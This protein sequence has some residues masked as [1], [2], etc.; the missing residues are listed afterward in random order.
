MW[1]YQHV[2]RDS[3]LL[4]ELWANIWTPFMWYEYTSTAQARRPLPKFRLLYSKHDA[5]FNTAIQF[6]INLTYS[7]IPNPYTDGNS[8]S[9]IQEIPQFLWM[10]CSLPRSQNVTHFLLAFQIKLYSSTVFHKAPHNTTLHLQLSF[11]KFCTLQASRLKFQKHLS[12]LLVLH[13]TLVS[14]SSIRWS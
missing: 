7:L 1:V 3:Q 14:P 4:T 2:P 12:P 8:L 11:Q 10:K 9:N 6:W 5:P 13:A